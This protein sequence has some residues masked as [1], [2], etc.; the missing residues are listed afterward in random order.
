MNCLECN[1]NGEIEI[2]SFDLNEEYK[3]CFY[4]EGTGEYIEL[5]DYIQKVG[6]LTGSRGM[7]FENEYSDWDYAITLN[8]FHFIQKY[9]G[10]YVTNELTVGSSNG[11]LLKN[12]I[13]VKFY[14]KN[15]LYNL[16]VYR[17]KE[18]LDIINRITK[19]VS[20]FN[21]AKNKRIRNSMFEHLCEL[22]ITSK[23][24]GIPEI[25]INED[26]IPF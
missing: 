10:N 18:C 22:L 14:Y 20:L 17:T 24:L 23:V 19:S 12:E 7:G 21:E 11:N 6:V 4:C 26:E 16:I 9:I 3:P 8:D 25:Q 2:V 5:E 13:S 15:K 1:G